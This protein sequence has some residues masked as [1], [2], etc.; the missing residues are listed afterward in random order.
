MNLPILTIIAFV[1][2]IVLLLVWI[3][4]KVNVIL[5]TRKNQRLTAALAELDKLTELTEEQ[6]ANLPIDTNES[7]PVVK[8]EDSFL[9]KWSLYARLRKKQ[10]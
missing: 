10:S 5:L 3:V 8:N 6:P 7:K 2:L 4:V 1:T 9:Q